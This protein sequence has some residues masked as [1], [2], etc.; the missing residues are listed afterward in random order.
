MLI[1]MEQKV[2]P[3]CHFPLT[4]NYYFC[5]NCGKQLKEPPI[6]IAKQLSVY[7]VSVLLPPLGLWPGIKYLLAESPQTKKVGIIAII[8]TVVSSIITIWLFMGIM[9]GVNQS[10]GSQMNQ[11]Q[12]LGY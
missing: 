7:A 11:Y 8:L 12:N 2:C 1:T 5:P 9:N 6:S 3:V 4:D 10:L